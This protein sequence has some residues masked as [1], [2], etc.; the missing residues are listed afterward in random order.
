MRNDRRIELERLNLGWNDARTER[1]LARVKTRI[2][3]RARVRRGLLASAALTSV[4]CIAAVALRSPP[5]SN[6]LTPV[7]AATP[8]LI[9][10]VEGSE[11]RVDPATSEVRVVEEQPSRVRVEAI[12]GRAHFSVV[13]NP[14]RSFEVGSGSVTVKVVGT[15]FLVE[16]R[17]D[18]T[19]VEISRGKGRELDWE[20]AVL[21]ASTDRAP[22]DTIGEVI[23]E[24]RARVMPILDEVHK[25]AVNI[26]AV[27]DPDSPLRRAMQSTANVAQ[28]L[29]RG[30]GTV[31]RLLA[32]NKMASDLQAAL[33][34][35][36]SAMA[37][38][39]GLM[40]ELE[41]SSKDARIATIIQRT[42]AVLASLQTVTRNMAAA[43]PQ[44]TQLTGNVSAATES[45][46]AL[47]L[48]T[49]MSAR[50]L[51]L[52]LGQLRRSWLLGGGTAPAATGRRAPAGEVRP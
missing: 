14:G 27:I 23:E 3:R 24:V 47:L 8:G 20:Y 34:N 16:R 7:A 22:T 52:L 28:R 33:A 11:I 1:L 15:E 43:S 5:S 48:Q 25:A 37:H 12:R 44:F 29:E 2:G 4:V 36:Q 50:E 9:R 42:D 38:A 21:T 18:K 39:N 19:Y 31:G 51:E 26:N 40:A 13:P 45:M 32:D 41:R 49:E 6:G 30:E 35:A 17:A 10:L 46:P